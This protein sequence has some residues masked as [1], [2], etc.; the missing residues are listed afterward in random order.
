MTIIKNTNIP[1][2]CYTTKVILI[3]IIYVG[4]RPQKREW[5]VGEW[6][7]TNLKGVNVLRNLPASST[8]INIL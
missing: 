2:K 8:D 4:T 7:C 3:T 5:G 6:G 1:E